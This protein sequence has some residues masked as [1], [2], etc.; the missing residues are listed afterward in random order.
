MITEGVG[1]PLNER[2]VCTLMSFC[3]V[4]SSPDYQLKPTR[5]HKTQ[6]AF[7]TIIAV[8]ESGSAEKPFVFLVEYLEKVPD[9]DAQSAPEHMRR[10]IYFASQAA[11]MQGTSSDRK[12]SEDMSPANAGKCRRLGKSPTDKELEKYEIAG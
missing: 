5:G 11:K 2:F 9:S 1:D 10:R 3:T 8:L 7:V 4:Q 12:W 6:M